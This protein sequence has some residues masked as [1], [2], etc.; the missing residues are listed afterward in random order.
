M[1]KCIMII[2]ALIYSFLGVQM[3]FAADTTPNQFK[4]IDKTKAALN[5]V[6]TSNT[7]KVSGIDTTTDLS[8]VGGT[9]SI[10]GGVYTSA[11][12]TV[13][14][15]DTVKVQQT[16]SG[17]PSTT[18]DATLTIG[19]VFDTFS[20]TTVPPD[21][22][23][24]K[25]R[26]TDQKNVAL[27]TLITSNTITVTGINTSA[28]ISIVGGEYSIN[29][30][31]Y[32]SDPG[33]VNNNDTV[34]L[35]QTSSASF[36]TKTDAI[37]TIGGVSDTFSVKTLA[38]D[39]KPDKFIF[40]PQTGVPLNTLITSNTITVTGINEMVP[41]SIVGG[42]YKIN[43]EAYTDAIGAVSNGDTVTVQQTSSGSSHKKTTA[44]LTIGKA[45]GKFSVTTR[46]HYVL[47]K[48]EF[49]F[50]N[51]GTF[52]EIIYYTY[53]ANGNNTK[54]E[55]DNDG[56][57]TI[58]MVFYYTY[59]ASGNKTKIEIDNDNNGTIDSILY[60]TYDANGNL[61]KWEYDYGNNGTIDAVGYYTYDANKNNTKWE[62]DSDNNGTIDEVRYYTYDANGNNTKIEYDY[63]NSGTINEVRYFIYD[64]NGNN[65]QTE[66][67]YDNNGTIDSILYSTYDANGNLKKD[68]DDY[69]NNGTIDNVIYYT[70]QKI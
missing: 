42:K 18:T 9:Y 11:P 8:I 27:I 38:A 22:K 2:I 32:T 24:K 36:S 4:F 64:A 69:G 28:D 53:D 15:N 61:T 10:N 43:D 30:G 6:Y 49:D 68:E 40:T 20:V 21:T 56:N 23:P 63:D 70:W 14:N 26:F 41:I 67:D 3:L 31:S 47:K 25:F 46:V 13:N 66:Y 52:N 5:T 60:S 50:G 33:T 35:Q 54:E 62:F 59:D 34:T 19:G 51:N 44:T 12:G 55:Y 65:T 39:P 16:S 37:L 17:I 48:I 1:K 58:D 7:I 57:G 45:K 29:G